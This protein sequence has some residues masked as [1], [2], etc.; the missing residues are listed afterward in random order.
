MK[1]VAAKGKQIDEFIERL[2]NI[3]SEVGDTQD[4][5]TVMLIHAILSYIA[6]SLNGGTVEIITQ[7]IA[8]YFTS[9]DISPGYH[10]S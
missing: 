1:K 3:R 4:G 6:C 7:A 2:S 8:G 9:D 5:N 10:S